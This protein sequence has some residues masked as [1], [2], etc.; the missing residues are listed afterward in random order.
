MI[1]VTFTCWEYGEGVPSCMWID[2]SNQ[3]TSADYF[4]SYNIYCKWCTGIAHIAMDCL[5]LPL[6]PNCKIV[7]QIHFAFWYMFAQLDT[8]YGVQHTQTPPPPPRDIWSSLSVRSM[9]YNINMEKPESWR[10]LGSG[11]RKGHVIHFLSFGLS[12]WLFRM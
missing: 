12:S 3:F 2:R 6:N 8:P 10:W 7:W 4:R 11:M 9:L 5:N 1:V